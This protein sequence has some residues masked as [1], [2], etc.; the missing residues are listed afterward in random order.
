MCSGRARNDALIKRA[1][2]RYAPPVTQRKASLL[3]ALSITVVCLVLLEVAAG[4]MF[5][6]SGDTN[7]KR[8]VL[9]ALQHQD[10]LV[11][12]TDSY[13]E[14]H[15]Y[16]LYVPRPGYQEFGFTQA[17]SLGYRGREFAHEK[18]PGTYRI[19]C[20]GGSTTLSYP[21]IQDPNGA[22][23]GLLETA[24]HERYPGRRFEVINAGLAYAT[25]AELLAGYMFRHRYLDPD[26]VIFHEGG[27]DADPLMFENYNPEYTH[28]R[29][30]GARV[31]IGHIERLLLRSNVFRIFFM[32]YWRYVPSI[33]VAQP[34]GFD[35]LDRDAT[36]K[37]VQETYPLGFERNLDL[38]MRTALADGAQV[39][40]AG[41]VA[42][43]E[44][45]L[46]KNW[47]SMKGL[48]RAAQ[49]GIDKNLRVMETLAATYRV[50][51]L[52]PSSVSFKDE[53]FVDGCHLN[54]EGEQFK[55][56]WILRGVT[57]VL[58][59]SAR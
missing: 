54:E 33:Y 21:F 1:Y 32:Y 16:L 3:L 46:A 51:Y 41:F 59:G 48:E 8:L 17:N 36:L 14:P 24:L 42:A 29:G 28:F 23:P 2:S 11:G 50:P 56:N 6:R 12:I 31:K 35:E 22:W 13:I 45:H 40:L 25:S 43:R 34:Y 39:M 30:P 58:D 44:E 19:L 15:P 26:M 37:R 9:S 38:I 55:A 4:F 47:P 49:V 10:N 27:N 20:L 7:G 53:W 52:S 18:A 57:A 5:R